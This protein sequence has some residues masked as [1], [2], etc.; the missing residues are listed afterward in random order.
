MAVA[1]IFKNTT[2]QRSTRTIDIDHANDATL[3]CFS[4]E[5]NNNSKQQ[6]INRK[7]M[8]E[9][10]ILLLLLTLVEFNSIITAVI[11]SVM[12]DTMPFTALR[13]AVEY[14]FNPILIHSVVFISNHQSDQGIHTVLFT[15]EYVYSLVFQLVSLHI[16]QQDLILHQASEFVIDIVHINI[17]CSE[18]ICE[19]TDSTDN[20]NLFA[21]DNIGFNFSCSFGIEKDLIDD[22][23]TILV[24]YYSNVQE[25]VTRSFQYSRVLSKH[26]NQRLH[27]YV[28]AATINDAYYR[29]KTLDFQYR[30]NEYDISNVQNINE[31][32]YIQF[33]CSI[34]IDDEFDLFP[35]VTV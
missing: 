28:D 22:I 26:S 23:T 30:T 5:Y 35:F 13:K 31:A 7:G 34:A 10:S 1:E 19:L 24:R 14:E 2:I 11:I 17:S 12:I 29:L 9:S 32:V 6:I 15:I 16:W 33:V 3:S 21:F 27:F 25:I 8:Q 20:S 18:A 4:N